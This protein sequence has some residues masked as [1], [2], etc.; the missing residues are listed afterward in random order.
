MGRAAVNTNRLNSQTVIHFSTNKVFVLIPL[1]DSMN[2]VRLLIV[3]VALA[4]V[5]QLVQSQNRPPQTKNYG[6]DR[7][8]SVEPLPQMNGPMCDADGGPAVENMLASMA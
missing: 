4:V 5:T 3:I 2:R 6:A 1:G 7:L 8:V